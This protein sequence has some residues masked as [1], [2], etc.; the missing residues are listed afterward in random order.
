MG[1]GERVYIIQDFFYE[2]VKKKNHTRDVKRK[3]VAI[4]YYDVRQ[5]AK[6]DGDG[7]KSIP[8]VII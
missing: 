4:N 8:Y 2:I 7:K 3:R 1:L 5:T 6:A